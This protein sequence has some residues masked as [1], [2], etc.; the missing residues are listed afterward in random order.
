MKLG[1]SVNEKINV[2]INDV[3]YEYG[4]LYDIIRLGMSHKL[5]RY[6]R[7]EIRN[8]TAFLDINFMIL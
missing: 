7:S 6:L 3:R 2:I 5:D 4:G 1:G 8:K